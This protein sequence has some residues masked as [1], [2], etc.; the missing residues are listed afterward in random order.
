MKKVKLMLIALFLTTA[1]IIAFRSAETGSIKGIIVPAEGANYAWAISGTDTVSTGITQ[2]VF[3]L[4]D[5]KPGVYQVLIQAVAPYKNATRE[6]VEVKDGEA[7]DI[8]QIT[9]EQTMSV[10]PLP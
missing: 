2:G 4:S 1:G 6:N 7:T 9:L 8:G 3:I 5:L 10:P